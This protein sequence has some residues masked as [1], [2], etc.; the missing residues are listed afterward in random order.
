M[1]ILDNIKYDSNKPLD[2]NSIIDTIQERDSIPNILLYDG[3]TIFVKETQENYQFREGS[4]K[5]LFNESMLSA[6][7]KCV[8]P[9]EYDNMIEFEPNTIYVL[10]EHHA[11]GG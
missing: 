1:V 5:P 4:W 7:I 9:D 11:P 10:V 6:K 3:K 8:S 2:A